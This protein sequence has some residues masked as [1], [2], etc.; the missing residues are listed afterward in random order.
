[1][2]IRGLVSKETVVLHW[3]GVEMTVWFYQQSCI[4]EVIWPQYR[5]LSDDVFKHQLALCQS[6]LGF[7]FTQTMG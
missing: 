1:M 6:K 3:W 7:G 4:D 5:D 2:D